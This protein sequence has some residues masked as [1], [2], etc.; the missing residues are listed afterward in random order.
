MILFCISISPWSSGTSHGT[1]FSVIIK[2]HK[3][4]EWSMK[5]SRPRW[6]GT[7]YTFQSVIK[8]QWKMPSGWL[9][10][11]FQIGISSLRCGL[12]RWTSL[13]KIPHVS[14][15]FHPKYKVLGRSDVISYPDLTLAS[16]WHYEF[17]TNIKNMFHFKNLTLF[18][19]NWTEQTSFFL[20]RNDM[21][22]GYPSMMS[23]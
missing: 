14:G 1:C 22:G 8:T 10:R 2:F 18:L 17:N 16:F 6:T 11:I 3:C 7:F 4:V 23:D 19:G 9:D 21:S 12:C 20:S 15:S 5:L 13:L